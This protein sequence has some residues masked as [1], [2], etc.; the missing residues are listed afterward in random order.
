MLF[1]R[2][3]GK[4]YILPTARVRLHSSV[5][6]ATAFAHPAKNSGCSPNNGVLLQSV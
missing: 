4:G 5:D 6:N 1:Q 3:V 2:R